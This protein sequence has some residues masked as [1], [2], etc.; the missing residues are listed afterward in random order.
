MSL[1]P[2]DTVG[3]YRLVER[4]GSGGMGE[5]WLAADD[6]PTADPAEVALKVI[7]DGRLG[8]PEARARFARE[9]EAAR[10]VDAPEVAQV[11]DADPDAESPW[12]ASRFVI[13][14]TLGERVGNAGPLHDDALRHLA[15][16]LA[17]GLDAIHRAGVV[18]RDLT[19]GNVILGPDG[20]V[21]VDFGVSR[22]DD[23][24]TITQAGSLVGTPA[25][26]APEQLR[27]GEVSAASDMWAWGAL[28]AYAATGRPL[29]SGERTETVIA[30]VLDGAL[31]LDGVPDWL[32]PVVTAA[33][34]RRPT[35]RP[36]A[37]ELV[38]RLD[39]SLRGLA[40]GDLTRIDPPTVVAP[41]HVRP[42][43]AESARAQSPGDGRT[44]G[45]DWRRLGLRVA[46]MVGGLV[47]GMALPGL[48]AVITFTI[49]VLLA[50]G[51][52]LW[53]EERRKGD[54]PVIN[55]G[56]ILVAALLLL[57]ASLSSLIGIWLAV[58]AVIALM[59]LFIAVGGDIG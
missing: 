9:I 21:I 40:A 7:A 55:G 51:V 5:V 41:A 23:T 52:R 44:G 27:D 37:D 36:T 2:G 58:I 53:T 38:A 1:S 31:D 46:T 48:I 20:P 17:R 43:M 34:D 11:L 30:K 22:V 59:A 13:G 3:P 16:G 10:R 57:A 33:T 18:H 19:P 54:P 49:G 15:L 4:I 56:T 28:M 42:T 50:G 26:M 29:V 12:L 32:A 25:W 47:A 39:R 45:R 6:R 24:T 35:H 14:A 8:D